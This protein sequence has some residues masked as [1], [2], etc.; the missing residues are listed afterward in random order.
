ML[1][2][3]NYGGVAERLKAA[4]LKMCGRNRAEISQSLT[5]VLVGAIRRDLG[6]VGAKLGNDL[7]NSEGAI[8][9]EVIR[10]LLAE[11][12]SLQSTYEDCHF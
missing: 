9:F 2:P 4:V 8:L 7:G 12:P 3:V 5:R 1:Q 6:G 10:H 11:L